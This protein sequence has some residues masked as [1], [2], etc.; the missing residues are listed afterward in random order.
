M[1]PIFDA[2]VSAHKSS[3]KS[4]WEDATLLFT[5]TN[6]I[7][8]LVGFKLKRNRAVSL[9]SLIAGVLAALALL[10]LTHFSREDDMN[11]ARE[12]TVATA[13]AADAQGKLFEQQGTLLLQTQ[14]LKST[15]RDLRNVSREADTAVAKL[16]GEIAD[17]DRR[18]GIETLIGRM[19]SDDAVA[20]DQLV[21]MKTFD[22]PEEE[23]RV[24]QAVEAMIDE[25][26]NASYRGSNF[27]SFR[28]YFPATLPEMP[29]RLLHKNAFFR[30]EALRDLTKYNDQPTLFPTVV[31][32][33]IHDPSLGVRTLAVRLI[34]DWSSQRFQPF[35]FDVQ[36]WWGGV[37]RS[38]PTSTVVQK[39]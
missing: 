2:I 16:K 1:I 37:A 14:Q 21:S 34:D 27:Q 5:V 7:F 38:Y 32:L 33:A 24:Y 3:P 29:Q 19:N 22:N 10:R 9:V 8:G 11:T 23:A 26:N 25:H 28:G 12:I 15:E 35:R 18:A 17:A 36:K 13:A 4:F 39:P 6:A 20:Y 30:E 31:D